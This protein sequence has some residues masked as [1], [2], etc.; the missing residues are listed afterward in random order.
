MNPIKI[1]VES[2]GKCVGYACS[3][4]KI[5]CSTAVYACSGDRAEQA[6]LDAATRCC[7][8]VTCDGC[9]GVVERG[10]TRCRAC[11][12]KDSAAKEQRRW[13]AAAKVQ[14]ADYPVGMVYR[15]GFGTEGYMHTS[16]I[17][18][19]LDESDDLDWAWGCAEIDVSADDCS[20]ENHVRETILQEHH[21]DAGENVDWEKVR[22]AEALLVEACKRVSS[23][24]QDM[25]V[26]VMLPREET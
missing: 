15:E 12:T 3:E 23:Y 8:C 24:Q 17:D 20:L 21:E 9:A 14:L 16:D 6:A 10:W 18:D 1:V 26:V 5:M 4:C 13:D 19:Y 22:A 11:R 2:S 25:S 7:A